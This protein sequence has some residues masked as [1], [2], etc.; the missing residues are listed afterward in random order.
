MLFVKRGGFDPATFIHYFNLLTRHGRLRVVR[1]SKKGFDW[2]AIAEPNVGFRV[3]GWRVNHVV[4]REAPRMALR[5]HIN[6][7]IVL[8]QRDAI[9][10]SHSVNYIDR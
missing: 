8:G 3:N 6:E 7:I 4:A 5:R 10:L 1:A 9:A 2:L